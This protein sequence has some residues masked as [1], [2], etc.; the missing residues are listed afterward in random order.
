M[1]VVV[2]AVVVRNRTAMLLR[3]LP[4]HQRGLTSKP[5]SYWGCPS[6]KTNQQ[7]VLPAF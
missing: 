3:I 7:P 4:P 5:A 2:V 1:P 6:M